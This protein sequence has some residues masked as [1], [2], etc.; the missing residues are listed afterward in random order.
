MQKEFNYENSINFIHSRPR[1]SKKVGLD[2]M[3]KLAHLLGNPQDRLKFIHV[4][5]TNGK[6]SY[7]SMVANCLTCAGYKVGLNISPFILDFRERFQINGEMITKEQLASITYKVYLACKQ[8][9]SDEQPNEFE[10]V[11]AIAFLFFAQNNCDIVC[12]ETGLGG[13]YDPTNIITTPLATCI[14]KI[15]LDHTQQLG[16]TT[17]EIA[18]QKAG[19]LKP[20]IP[21]VVYPKN[22]KTD[23]DEIEKIAKLENAT[24]NI[25]S[26][27]NLIVDCNE[28]SGFYLKCNYKNISFVPPFLGEHQIYNCTCVI[29]T[30]LLLNNM[31][32]NISNNAIS[33]GLETTVFPARTEIISKKP[34]VIL[35]GCHNVDSVTAFC[36]TLKQ[37]NLKDMVLIVGVLQDKQPLQMLQLFA[38]HFKSVVCVNVNNP[39]TLDCETHASYCQNLFENVSAAASFEQAVEIAI[40]DD[41]FCNGLCVCGSLYLA[42]QSRTYLLDKF[43]QK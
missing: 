9:D 18:I 14:M 1:F 25:P 42:S 13:L 30:I 8:L 32:Y 20:D 7:C 34:L 11:T 2:V 38:K 12:L 4:A 31:G 6:G 27:D 17:K 41:Y 23:V 3:R 35:D 15:G 26:I 29:E 10:V 39:R 40:N 36:D 33:K 22:C 19:I 16:N 37:L 5:G 43:K 24:L 21:C 28:D